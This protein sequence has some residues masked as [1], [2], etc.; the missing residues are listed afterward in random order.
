MLAD[1]LEAS[2]GF[3]A[4]LDLIPVLAFHPPDAVADLMALTPPG[5][6]MQPQRGIDLGERMAN[7]FAEAAAAGAERV[8]LRGSDSPT[9]D[10]S[11]LETAM[12]RL[13]GGDDLVLTPDQSGGYAMVGMRAPQPAL[14]DLAMSTADMMEQTLRV[15]A[16]L[17]LRSSSTAASFDL[18]TME[19]FRCFDGLPLTQ[20]LD[21][22]PRTVKSISSLPIDVV[23]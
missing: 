3:A 7:A 12:N 11:I 2:A 20:L 14:F 4:A 13:D 16:S 23:L 1:V 5:F 18:D 15:A 8:L 17:G 19:D 10:G 6:R 9:L 22:C 21:L